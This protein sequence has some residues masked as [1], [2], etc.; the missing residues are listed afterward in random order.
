MGAP[1]LW[2]L[3]RHRVDFFE[4]VLGKPACRGRYR[5]TAELEQRSYIGRQRQR[6]SAAGRERAHYNPKAR[7]VCI[8]AARGLDWN[9]GSY[10]LE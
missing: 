3:R 6:Q 2:I 9:R 10:L 1:Q 4:V 8:M 5:R 7:H